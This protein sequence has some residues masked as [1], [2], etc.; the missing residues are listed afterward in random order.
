MAFFGTS[1][2]SVKS[3]IGIAVSIYV[4]FAIINK[5]LNFARSSREM[6]QI[7]SLN[8]VE[9][10]PVDIVPFA[11]SHDFRANS[12][13]Q[14]ADSLPKTLGLGCAPLTK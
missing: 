1:G 13:R 11:Y 14:A 10:T 7:L 3:Q 9:K 6:L 12:R 2:I 4:P 5:H 8:L